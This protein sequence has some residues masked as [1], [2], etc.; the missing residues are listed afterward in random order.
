MRSRLL[1]YSGVGRPN[2]ENVFHFGARRQF[3]IMESPE[4]QR[5]IRDLE[6][7]DLGETFV[8]DDSCGC[9]CLGQEGG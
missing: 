8:N 3:T 6:S 9:S 4:Q 1:L 5:T 2:L 7:T